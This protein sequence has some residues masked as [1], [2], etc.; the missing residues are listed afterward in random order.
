MLKERWAG[1]RYSADQARA[2]SGIA[3]IRYLDQF[4]N[5]FFTLARG[6]N[7]SSLWLDLYK[8]AP[9]E[10]DDSA[11][12]FAEKT[13]EAFPW[14]NIQNILPKMRSLRTIKAQCELEAMKKAEIITKA[15]ILAMMKSA[16]PSIYEYELKAAFD[17]ALTSQSVV[18]PAFQPIISTG[19]NNFCIHYDQYNGQS[20][21]GDMILNDVGA[22]WDGIA[23]D[24]SRGWPVNGKFTK[25]QSALYTAAYNT[26]NYMFSIIKPGMPM[27]S[28]DETARRICFDELKKIGLIENYDNIGKYMWH[29]GAHHVGWDVHDVVT[30]E[31]GGIQPGMVFCVDVGIYNE[32]WGIGFRLE[33]NC[34]VT[35][36]GC[37]NLSAD[38]PRSIEDIEAVMRS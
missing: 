25:E 38:I 13:R 18:R 14:L 30:Q 35:E 6:G 22:Q 11:Y 21:D 4:E 33:D 36:S 32:D 28:V 27:K 7:V 9:G 5:D 10:A 20:K 15:G 31:M 1:R 37:I 2:L 17:Y 34:L 29:G 12:L 23:T 16:R 19:D 26:S 3:D 24:V 8:H